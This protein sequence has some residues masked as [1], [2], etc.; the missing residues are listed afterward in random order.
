MALGELAFC[1]GSYIG[2]FEKAV[3]RPQLELSKLFDEILGSGKHLQRLCLLARASKV[4]DYFADAA[5]LERQ[6]TVLSEFSPMLV[7]GLLQTEAYARA[8][9]R[10]ARRF[11]PQQTIDDIV[12]ARMERTQLL[13]G[14]SAPVDWTIIHETALRLPTGGAAVMAEQLGHLAHLL[15]SRP[16]IVLQ[17]MPFSAGPHPFLGCLVSLMQFSDAPPVLYTESAYNGWVIDEPTVV[18]RYQSAYDL[19][20]AAAL[21]PE[22]S[23]DL[24]ESAAKDWAKDGQHS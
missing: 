4:A 17:V 23:L 10:A 15:R 16:N 19:A 8:L 7:P 2:Q 9:I 12:S 1:S 13:D 11:D 14:P 5:D 3:R 18:A 22:A 20:R 21:S 6:A 24:I